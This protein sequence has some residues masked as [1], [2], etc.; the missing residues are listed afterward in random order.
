MVQVSVFLFICLL[1]S[2]LLSVGPRTLDKCSST[3]LHLQCHEE[4]LLEFYQHKFETFQDKWEL[5][6]YVELNHK[7]GWSKAVL[8]CGA[9]T[10]PMWWPHVCVVPALRRQRQKG[11]EFKTNLS[12]MVKPCLRKQRSGGLLLEASLSKM[13]ARPHLNKNPGLVVRVCHL[14]HGEIK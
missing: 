5:G 7:R 10:Q 3:E 14:S 13:F 11:H 8:D 12:Y 2:I 9:D 1:F 4:K 6:L